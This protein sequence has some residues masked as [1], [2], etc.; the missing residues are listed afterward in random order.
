MTTAKRRVRMGMIGGG[1]GAFIGRVH[2]LAAALD[3]ELELVCASFSR[4]PGNNARTGEACGLSAQ[5]LYPDWQSLIDGE[6]RLPDDQ[7]MDVL[8]VVTPN[9]LHVPISQA[10]LEAGF[11]VFCEKPAATTLEEA[12]Q[13]AATLD[14]GTSLYGLA[15]TYLGYPMVWQARRLVRDG[16]LGR[17]RKIHVEYPQGWLSTNLEGTGNKQAGWRTDPAIAGA[18]GCMADIGT[19]AFGLAEF[20]SGHHVTELCAALGTHGEQRRLDDDG[21]ALFQTAEGASGTLM[22][23][24]VCTGEENALKIRLYGDRG[25]LEW[26]QMEPNTLVHRR[27][28]EPMR[29]LRAG[30]DQPGLAPEALERLRLPGGHPEGYLEA[31]ANLYR[32]FADAVRRGEHGA[33]AGVPGMEEGLRGMAFIEALLKSQAG[34][35][36]WTSLE[37]TSQRHD[38]ETTT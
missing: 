23:S 38:A 35:S 22:A 8:V 37:D 30:I 12:R 25:A 20:I 11:H 33:A 26:Q 28:D 2:R 4:D 16:E 5:R 15:H 6:R 9:H 1:E 13:L 24:Q 18:S 14:V 34:T 19:H 32:D 17:L 27:L 10:A 3:G 36:K 21:D 7:R 29:V 31:L